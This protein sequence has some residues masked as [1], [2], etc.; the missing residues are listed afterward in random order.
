M[1][2]KLN[3]PDYLSV[4]HWKQFVASEHLE[5]TEKMVSM[6]ATLSDKTEEEIK[7]YTPM[8]LK[9]V[10]EAVLKSLNEL[11]PSFYPV[12][13]LDNV[14]YGF[15]SITSLTLGEYVD[16]ERLAKKPQENIEEI[17]AILYRPIV[18]NK[19][20]GIKWAFKN[21]HKV[22]LGEAENLFKYYQVETYDSSL[23]KE[24]AEKLSVIPAS[25]A[26]GALSFFLVL[27]NSSLI[28][29]NLSSL[30]EKEQMKTMK[31]M[32]KQMASMNIGDGL[33][34]F[35]TSLQHPSFQSQTILQY[36]S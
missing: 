11:E 3:I 19:F 14:L 33:R 34:R 21:K 23:R 31:Q 4:K 26:L 1:E 27:A 6:L 13:E 5:P 30:N 15:T 17:M 36:Q 12:F 35:I 7:G 8:A 9:Q 28:G 20:S 2:I 32:N 16:L 29:M 10:Y 24:N 25:L 22:A 18:K